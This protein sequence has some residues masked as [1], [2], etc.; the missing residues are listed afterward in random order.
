MIKSHLA[1]NKRSAFVLPRPSPDWK[2]IAD[3]NARQREPPY[4]SAEWTS[5]VRAESLKRTSQ[6]Q[7]GPRNSLPLEVENRP[8]AQECGKYSTPTQESGLTGLSGP[9]AS[10]SQGWPPERLHK[11]ACAEPCRSSDP[12]RLQARIRRSL[13]SLA[14]YSGY[15]D[16]MASR[17]WVKPQF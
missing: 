12:R 8:S 13:S 15:S 5:I 2:P 16:A 11:P 1:N 9:R 3:P 6:S 10:C 4:A 17:H 7:N 14:K